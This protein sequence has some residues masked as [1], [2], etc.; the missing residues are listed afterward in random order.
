M[1]SKKWI[2]IILAVALCTALYGC[3]KENE[4][5]SVVPAP[6]L[7]PDDSLSITGNVELALNE[8]HE[9]TVTCTSDIPQE[10]FVTIY[11]MDDMG[12]MLD[13]THDVIQHN[14]V[15]YATF[16]ADSSDATAREN[17]AHAIMARVEFYP[18]ISEQPIAIREKFGSKGN[19]LAGDNIVVDDTTGDIGVRM[20]STVRDLI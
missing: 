17:D 14:G 20:E 1:N 3:S 19:K 6:T 9:Y 12:N 5:Q 10:A 7:A 16:D 11:L 2:C 18:S 13:V 8:N 15:C 4:Q